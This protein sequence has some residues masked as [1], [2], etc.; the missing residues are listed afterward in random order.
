MPH[1]IIKQKE[2]KKK[3]FVETLNYFAL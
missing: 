2:N 3:L 1:V